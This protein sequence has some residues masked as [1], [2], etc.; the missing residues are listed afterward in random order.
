MIASWM[1]YACLVAALVTI[2]A[3]AMERVARA[4]QWPIRFVWIAALLLSIAWPVGSAARGL[5]PAGTTRVTVLPFT[6][7]VEPTR[8]IAR[9]SLAPDRAALIDRGLVVLWCAFSALLLIRLSRGI[10]ELQRTRRAWK[11]G[12]IDGTAVRLSDNV[13]PAVVGLRSMD[14]VVPEWVMTL[15]APLR[16]IVLRHE[17]EHRAARDPYLLFTAAVGVVLM[18]WNLAL[19]MQARR[20]RLAIEMDCD[21][22]V[23]RAHPSPERYGLLMLTIAQRRSVAPTLFAPMLTEPTTQLERRILAMRTT[24]HGLGRLTM[25]GGTAVATAALTV[26]FSLQSGG[27]TFAAAAAAA[28]I[29]PPRITAPHGPN[30]SPRYP[31]MLRSAE[32]EGTVVM[33]WTNDASGV[34]D[35]NTF[36]VVSSTH[37]LFTN[38]VLGVLQSWHM[39]PNTSVEVPF[40]FVLTNLTAARPFDAPTNAVIVMDSPPEANE[41]PAPRGPPMRVSDNQTFFEFQVENQV[42]PRPGYQAPRYPDAL[43]EAHV[44]G[45]VLAQFV[46]DTAGVPVTETFK[47]LKSSHELFTDAVRTALPDMLFYPALVGNRPVKQLVQMPFQF[48]LSKENRVP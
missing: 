13:G 36:K 38:A 28:T 40:V 30:P 21:V 2:A 25:Y 5:M 4:R 42:K 22:R 24:T 23:L 41:P 45:E 18:P 32:I 31:Q 39:A 37:Q 12:R 35:I 8:I 29:A 48:N 20:L 47:V 16:A 27:R 14:V 34:P 43:R 9:G 6:I 15:D 44:E 7:A 17:E 3:E 11:R 46:V 1:L 33:Q 26:A 19:W 10:V